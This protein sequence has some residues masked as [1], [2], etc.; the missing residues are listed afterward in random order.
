MT[1]AEKQRVY[2]TVKVH[3]IWS[4]NSTFYYKSCC[5]SAK[6][7]PLIYFHNQIISNFI[8]RTYYVDKSVAMVMIL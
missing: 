4:A 1:T 3:Q 5:E 7:G 8:L 2:V 6:I